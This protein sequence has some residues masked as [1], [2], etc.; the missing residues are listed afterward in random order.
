MTEGERAAPAGIGSS[1]ALS[2]VLAAFCLL[3]M[4]R[5]AIEAFSLSGSVSLEPVRAA[6]FAPATASALEASLTTSIGGTLLAVGLGT[7]VA[8]CV[9]LTPMRGRTLFVFCF[10]LP[11]M[12]APQVTALAW[13]QVFGPSSPLLKLIGLPPALGARNPLYSRGGIILLLGLQY[14]PL[15]FLVL[16]AQMRSLPLALIEAARAAGAPPL[17]I[18]TTII[19][20]L[21][22]PAFVAGAALCFVSCFGNFGIPAFLGAPANIVTLPTYIYQLLSGQ[23][24]AVLPRVAALSLL[25]GAIAIAGLMLQGVMAGRRSYA[26]EA[27]SRRI[28]PFELGRGRLLVEAAM[29]LLILVMLIVPV[30]SLLASALVGGLGVGLSL[31]TLTFANFSYV[32]F[33]HEAARRALLNSFTL[34]LAAAAIIVAIAIPLGYLGAWRPARLMRILIVAAELPYAVPGVVLA[35]AS[36]LLFLKPLPLL[37]LSLYNTPFI[38]LFAYVARFMILGLRPLV[39]GFRQFDRALD[40]AAQ[41]A[42]AGLL[43][44]LATIIVP[45]LAPIAAA[46]FLLIFLTAFNELTVSALLWSSGSETLGVVLFSFEQGGDSGLACAIAILTI[47]II[48]VLMLS[49]SLFAGRLP[50]GTLPWRA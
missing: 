3:P 27:L 42:G 29:A 47:A 43:R 16:G 11:L 40:E 15:M 2:L 34:S 25:V 1:A 13:L 35:I 12:I 21:L 14:A 24:P 22:T 44:R 4:G 50:R 10:V 33:E 17:W 9:H 19:L 30:A 28:E 37:G 45:L 36:I 8:L 23:G 39:A 31:S 32:L 49:A 26:I 6:L 46:G 18:V 38:I 5:L 41:I 7:L 48:A 20:P